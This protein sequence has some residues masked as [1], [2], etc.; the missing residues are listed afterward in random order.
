MKKPGLLLLLCGNLYLAIA[1]KRPLPVIDMHLHALHANDQGP[2]PITVGI[3]F[4]DFGVHDPKYD[5][6][7]AFT[8]ALKSHAWADQFIT[9]PTTDD[10]LKNLTIA[11]LNK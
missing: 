5:Y 9:S 11:A 4:R 3:P 2:A 7:D 1:Q 6:R 8:K 10:S